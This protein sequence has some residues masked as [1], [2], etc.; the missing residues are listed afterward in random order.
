MFKAKGTSP[1]NEHYCSKP[2]AECHCVHCK[3]APPPLEGPYR[4][5]VCPQASGDRT[6]LVILRDA[7]KSGKRKRELI[8]DDAL[9]P[10]YAKHMKL[11]HMAQSLYP[12]PPKAKKVV[13]LYGPSGCGKTRL[14]YE[15]HTLEDLYAKPVDDKFWFD[16]YDQ[17][18]TVLLDDFAGRVSKLSLVNLLRL[19]DRYPIQLPFKGGYVWF[20][21]DTIYLT[22]NIHPRNWY[23]WVGREPQYPALSRRITEVRAWRADGLTYRQYNTHEEVQSFFTSYLR[24]PR[25][26]GDDSYFNFIDE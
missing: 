15:T 18:P 20:S 14:V 3:D 16:G 26:S 12:P 22:S 7:V 10:T 25:V 1:Q 8:E 5:G 4:Y 17:H 2:V 24:V 21:P 9:L 23:E 19:L 6:D 13:L 11:A